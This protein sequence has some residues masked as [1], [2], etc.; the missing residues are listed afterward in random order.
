MLAFGLCHI[1]RR[2]GLLDDA[3]IASHVEGYQE[4]EETIA[5]ADPESTSRVTGVPVRLIEETAHLYARGPSLLWLGQG[6]QRQFRGGN[7][8]RACAMLPALTGNISKP[9]TGIFYL[10]STLDIMARKGTTPPRPEARE[11]G[12]SISQMDVPAALDT[13]DR[14]GAYMV[15]NCNPLASNP[16]Q[17]V[18]TRALTRQNLFTV[19]R[20]RECKLFP[21]PSRRPGPVCRTHG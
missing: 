1:A 11:T 15:W 18:L 14:F 7:I 2:D 4:V 6:L 20:R 13:T 21:P 8:F 9:G 5:A 10:N 19:V 17:Q 16:A 12:P 3:W